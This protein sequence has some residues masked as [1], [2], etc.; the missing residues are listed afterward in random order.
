M[1]CAIIWAPKA[2][3]DLEKIRH[4]WEERDPDGVEPVIRS[5]ADAVIRLGN[6]PFVGDLRYRTRSREYR[7]FQGGSYR[8]YFFVEEAINRITIQRV[9]H[10][11]R[12]V[13]KSFD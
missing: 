9:W 5:I 10:H 7:E 13:P 3:S 2:L 1:V 4:Y 11:A 8:V 6:S 12:N